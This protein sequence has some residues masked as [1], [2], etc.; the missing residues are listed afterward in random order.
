MMDKVTIEQDESPRT[1]EVEPKHHITDVDSD[2]LLD[3]GMA[4]GEEAAKIGNVKFA[5]N[6]HVSRP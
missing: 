1:P 6:G 4:G 2:I 5:K 3:A